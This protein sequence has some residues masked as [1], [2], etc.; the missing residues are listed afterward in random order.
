MDEILVSVNGTIT[1]SKNAM[2]PALDRGF[3]Y[4]DS[5]YE[6]TRTFDKKIFHWKFHINRLF[7]SAKIIHLP[8]KLTEEQITN[9]VQNIIDR[10]PAK[11]LNIRIQIS[12]GTNKFLGFSRSLTDGNNNLIIIASPLKTNPPHWLT[13]GVRL[14]SFT[15]SLNKSGSQSKSGSYYENVM[16][17]ELAVENGFDD[18]V[19]FNKDGLLLEGTTFNIWFVDKDN[20]VHTPAL[21]HGLLDG[22]TRQCLIRLFHS[23]SISVNE[24]DFSYN[25]LIQARE[26]FIT[27]SSRFI[28]PVTKID[29]K[30]ISDGTVGKK[31]I[32]YL[33]LYLEDIRKEYNI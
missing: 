21:R 33:N 31:T 11:H 6:A 5:V 13:D 20:T 12:G 3:L 2:I 32:E 9:E 22:I 24:G 4:A 27:S 30:L 15:S 23:K 29:S 28:V 14:M 16:A 25:D 7:E 18:A 19:I 8:I 26:V 17:Y 10:H 1:N